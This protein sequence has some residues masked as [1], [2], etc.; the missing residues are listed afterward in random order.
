M[1]YRIFLLIVLLSWPVVI[2]GILFLMSKLEAYVTRMDAKTPEEAGLDP[3]SG[4][5]ADREVKIVFGDQ[6]VGESK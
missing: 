6:V 2:I 3:V 1:A 5:A 4:E